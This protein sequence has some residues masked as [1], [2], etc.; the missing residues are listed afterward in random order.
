MKYIVTLGIHKFGI[1]DGATALNFAELAKKYFI[2][3][4][5]NKKLD[6][7]VSIEDESEDEDDEGHDI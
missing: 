6:P 4:Q 5:Y 1:P 7:L 3:T 2:P